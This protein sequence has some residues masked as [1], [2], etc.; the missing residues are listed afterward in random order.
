LSYYF[1]A[2]AVGIKAIDGVVLAADKRMSYNGFVMSR[3]VRKV[4]VI[5]DR[6]AVAVTGFYAD[7]SGLQRMMEAEIRYYEMENNRRLPLKAVAKLLSSIL[8]SYKFTPFYV[9]TIVGGIDSD[10][11]PKIYVLDPVGAI[12]EEKFIATGSGA[13]LALGVIESEYKDD[14]NLE[15]AA[16]LA[17]RAMRAAIGRDAGTGDGIDIVKV[18]K[19]GG[20]E[21][22]TYRLKVVEL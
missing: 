16:D 7:I 8:Y 2:T 20:Y 3:N 17:L 14:I 15:R 11:E 18:K 6:I 13:T 5:N 10:G 1:G 21:I 9:E 12:T 19:E 4:F 22:K